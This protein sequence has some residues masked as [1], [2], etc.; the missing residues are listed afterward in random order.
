MKSKSTLAGMV[1]KDENIIWEGKPNI[2]CFFLEAI[3]NVMLPVAIL[4]GVL[5]YILIKY[6]VNGDSVLITIDES[7]ALIPLIIL[8]IVILAPLWLYLVGVLFSILKY[9][10]TEFIVTDKYIYSSGGFIKKFYERKSYNE[11]SHIVLHRGI[12]DRLIGVGDI[13][14]STDY[15]EH[16][17]FEQHTAYIGLTVYDISDFNKL[18]EETTRIKENL[19]AQS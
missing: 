15:I 9:A 1:S 6:L 18:Y 17:L 14:F 16:S 13:T 8:F 19:Q 12:I 5:Y 3:F 4:W 10:H 11:I 7:T 2:I